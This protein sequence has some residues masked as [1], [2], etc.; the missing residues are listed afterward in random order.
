MDDRCF[1]DQTDGELA[2][3]VLFWEGNGPGPEAYLELKRRYPATWP[4]TLE[5]M[6]DGE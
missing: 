3:K 6:A 4:A 2:R 5:E 1:A